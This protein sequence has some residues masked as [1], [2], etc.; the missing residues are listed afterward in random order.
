MVKRRIVLS[1][2]EM[3]DITARIKLLESQLSRSNKCVA[4]LESGVRK[5]Q[6][7]VNTKSKQKKPDKLFEE[8][9]ALCDRTINP[10]VKVKEER[11]AEEHGEEAIAG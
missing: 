10:P 6:K 11:L 8:V 9:T 7:L 2:Q 5:I 1:S 4:D 3:N